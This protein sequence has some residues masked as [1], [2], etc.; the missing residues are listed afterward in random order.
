MADAEVK[1]E[2]AKANMSY[3]DYSKQAMFDGPIAGQSLMEDPS[4]PRPDEQ[5]PLFTAIRPALEYTW[6]KLIEPA[7]YTKVMTLLGNEM[8]VLTLVKGMLFVGVR[9]GKW[10]P[11]LMML[12]IEPVAYMLIAL[13]ERQEIPLVLYSGEDEDEDAEEETMG[14]AMEEERMA[15]LKRNAEAS[16]VP[17]G[18]LSAQMQADLAAIPQ[19]SSFDG[20]EL[21]SSTTGEQ[22]P[23]IDDAPAPEPVEPQQS[24]MSKPE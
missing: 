1:Q 15:D 22:Q 2:Q 4:S 8:P 9:D 16:R 20:G 7:N 18:I 23:S 24:L 17:E 21:N 5:P 12:M 13:A 10:N 14:V 3:E 6:G 19:Q 11:D